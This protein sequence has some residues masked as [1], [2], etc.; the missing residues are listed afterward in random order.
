MDTQ[1]VKKVAAD[2]SL[3]LLSHEGKF[4]FRRLV[5]AHCW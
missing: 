1:V 3:E 2:G 4:M 5:R